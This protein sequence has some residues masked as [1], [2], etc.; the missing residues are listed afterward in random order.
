MKK[1]YIIRHGQT[2]FN[3]LGM[4]QGSGVDSGLN[5]LGRAQG[6]AF[7]EH[8]Q[9]L[10]FEKVYT[11]ALKRTIETVSHFI[12]RGMPWEANPGFNEI[13]WG[14]KEGRSIT[15]A[16]DKQYFDMLDGWRRGELDLKVDG[17][18]SPLDV[19]A[20]LIE[21]WEPLIEGPERTVLVCIHG[22]AMRILLCHLLNK[23]L[24]QM[25]KFAHSNTCLYVL[26][27][28]NGRYSLEVHNDTSHLANL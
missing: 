5:D 2:D 9:H 11:S 15:E 14:D 28:E 3:R 27:Y 7:F 12:E 19:C 13:S 23:H 8:Y 16:D 24:S 26:H 22:R 21:A 20:R 1:I 25:D 6:K 18:E 10:P 17:G 4:V